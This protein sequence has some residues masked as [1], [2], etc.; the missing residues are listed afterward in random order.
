MNPNNP[1]LTTKQIWILQT[2]R[3]HWERHHEDID[4]DQLLESLP[5]ETTKASVQFSIRALIKKGM[6]LKCECEVRRCRK[7]RVIK[8]TPF[9]KTM[10]G[11]SSEPVSVVGI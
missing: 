8:I 5:Y 1:N 4:I 11:I 6:I 2:I 10:L 9:A 7:R 3:K